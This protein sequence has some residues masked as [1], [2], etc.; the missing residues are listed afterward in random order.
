MF[1]DQTWFEAGELLSLGES[2]ASSKGANVNLLFTEPQYAV[3]VPG[4]TVSSAAGVFYVQ[5]QNSNFTDE[6]CALMADADEHI[7]WATEAFGKKSLPH[8]IRTRKL[9]QSWQLYLQLQHRYR[10]GN[11]LWKRMQLQ[12]LRVTCTNDVSVFQERCQMP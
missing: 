5:K 7:D 10:L 8:S 1:L 11:S 3:E 4:A 2:L 9:Q 12:K 6:F